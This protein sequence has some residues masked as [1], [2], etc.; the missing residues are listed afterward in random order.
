MMHSLAPIV[1]INT[2]GPRLFT[3]SLHAPHIAAVV[4]PGQFL[5]IQISEYGV[6]FLRRP[7]SVYERTDSVVSILFG[8]VGAGTSLLSRAVAGEFLDVV[9]PLGVPFRIDDA[10]DTALLVAGGLGVAPLPFLAETV[11]TKMKK[12]QTFL[13]A[14]TADQIVDS[15]LEN[16]H[17]AT[18]DGTR[19][20]RG[21]IVECLKQ[22]LQKFGSD[23]MKIFACGPTA[24]IKALV[25]VSGEYQI[26]CEVSLE[27]V[28]AC[29][30]GICQGC[31]VELSDSPK[32]Y[33]LVCKDGTVFDIRSIHLP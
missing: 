4:Q 17:I 1:E 27:S 28:M 31:P 2:I 18:D 16:V 19:G 5:N 30:I 3:I 25:P 23:Q 24:M 33:A 14:R 7:F 8:V 26:P 13:G 10:Y 15:H 21:T 9:G 11:R 12:M 22:Y 32:K 6:P 29:G 20:Y